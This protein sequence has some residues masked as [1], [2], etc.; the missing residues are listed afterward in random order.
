MMT[1]FLFIRSLGLPKKG[2]IYTRDLVDLLPVFCDFRLIDLQKRAMNLLEKGSGSTGNMVD[3]LPVFSNLR[4]IGLLK[5]GNES[6][7]KGQWIY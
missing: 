6:T 1:V 3:L 5:K 2:N 7:R 4:S